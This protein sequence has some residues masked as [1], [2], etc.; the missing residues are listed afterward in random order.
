[1]YTSGVQRRFKSSPKLLRYIKEAFLVRFTEGTYSG[2]SIYEET[3]VYEQEAVGE[4]I[5]T[6][7]I[8][9]ACQ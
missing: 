1:M 9:G 2:D 7:I 4:A 5:L 3:I 6:K 8:S